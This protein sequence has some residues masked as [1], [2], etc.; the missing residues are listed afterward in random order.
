MKVKKSIAIIWGFFTLLPVVT[1][2]YTMYIFGENPI[3]PGENFKAWD[4]HFQQVKQ[5]MFVSQGILFAVLMSYIV[6]LFRTK[7]VR[8][9]KKALWAVVLFLGNFV[10][11][12]IFWYHYVWKPANNSKNS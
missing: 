7:H 1:F 10:A 3:D 11:M 6:Y 2:F 12:P 4:I 5:I 9:D 8:Q